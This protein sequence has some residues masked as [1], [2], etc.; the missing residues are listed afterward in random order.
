MKSVESKL[1]TPLFVEVASSAEII[2]E[3]PVTAT[4]IPSPPFTS[5]VSVKRLIPIVA[6]VSSDI[7]R[8]VATSTSPAA[9]K[10]P[11]A[12]TVNVGIFVCDP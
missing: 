2:I 12:S 6:D 7:V 5:S 1:A 9:V 3:S 10:R 8:V 11:C 4:S